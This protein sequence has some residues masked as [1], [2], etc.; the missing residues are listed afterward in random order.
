MLIN[1]SA[2]NQG[3]LNGASLQTAVANVSSTQLQSA[4][5]S[6]LLSVTAS[7]AFQ[8]SNTSQITSTRLV[9]VS[10][11]SNQASTVSAD[12]SLVV[13]TQVST[14]QIQT[15]DVASNVVCKV[16]TSQAQKGSISTSWVVTESAEQI[17]AVKSGQSVQS[18]TAV[19]VCAVTGNAKSVQNQSNQQATER[20][21]YSDWASAQ[22]EKLL[23]SVS[24]EVSSVG[25]S[26]QRHSSSIWL[27]RNVSGT[28]FS[29]ASQEMFAEL[30]RSIYASNNTSNIQFNVSRCR[31]FSLTVSINLLTVPEYDYVAFVESPQTTVVVPSFTSYTEYI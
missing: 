1:S 27:E 29:K 8:Q 6:S 25:I 24:R 22:V 21:I 11:Y 4:S 23:A 12:A 26:S 5:I 15:T 17:N 2:L 30:M 16:I 13:D 10:C 19:A 28:V 31:G 18:S 9:D 3:T 20:A 7:S 14:S